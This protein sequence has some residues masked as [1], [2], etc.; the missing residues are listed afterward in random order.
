MLCV[1]QIS[2][3]LMS[4]DLFL[5]VS[6]LFLLIINISI[7]QLEVKIMTMMK[8]FLAVF[9]VGLSSTNEHWFVFD[10]YQFSQGFY[11]ELFT[12]IQTEGKSLSFALSTYDRSIIVNIN[13]QNSSEIIKLNIERADLLYNTINHMIFIVI[14]NDN[15]FET[16]VN[17]KLIDSY[18]FY[19]T[20]LNNEKSFYKLKT[21]A[22]NIEYYQMTSNNQQEI[23]DKYSCKQTDTNN[24]T[25]IIGR[26]LIRQ[27]QR[28]IEKV[29]RRK[30]RS[31]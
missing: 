29:Q 12:L 21:L 30:L 22:E 27:M 6:F 28:V 24:S 17:C 23:F 19:S 31:R 16:Y 11:T 13:D 26:S 1:Y 4:Y 18:L 5:S 7:E 8:I 3:S 10:Q 9:F 14:R 20:I 2:F 25:S 15:K